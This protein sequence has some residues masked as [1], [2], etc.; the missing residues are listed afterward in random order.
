MGSSTNDASI[1]V[2]WIALG[3]MAGY[4]FAPFQGQPEILAGF[5]IGAEYNIVNTTTIGNG[6][7]NSTTIPTT[8]TVYPRFRAT[9]G[10]AF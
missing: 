3:G 10:Y 4:Q 9:I 5:G 7:L 1:N 2:T 8:N 6:V